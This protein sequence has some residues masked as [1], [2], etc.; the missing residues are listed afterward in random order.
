VGFVMC[1]AVLCVWSGASERAV[2]LA[3]PREAQMGMFQGGPGM[4]ASQFG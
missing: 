1:I 3:T 2:R 4:A